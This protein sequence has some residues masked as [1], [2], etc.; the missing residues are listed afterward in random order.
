MN[1]S[2]LI[3]GL[4]GAL[5]ALSLLVLLAHS[6]APQRADA[7]APPPPIG[8]DRVL[9]DPGTPYEEPENN[10]QEPTD[11]QPPEGI[12]GGTGGA[13]IVAPDPLPPSTRRQADRRWL[14]LSLQTWQ[15]HLRLLLKF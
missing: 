10:P 7:I 12:S 6:L 1:P 2:R 4:L 8:K 11:P 5:V 15:F 3:K 13:P 9:G 14:N